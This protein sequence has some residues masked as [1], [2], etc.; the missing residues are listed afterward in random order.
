MLIES[1]VIALIIGFLSGGKLNPLLEVRLR[2]VGLLFLGALL[3]ALAFWSVRLNLELGHGIIPVVH[4]ISY[5]F[6]LMFTAYNRSLPGLLWISLGILLNAVVIS[7]NGGLMPVDPSFVPEVSRELLLV[8]TG[9]HGIL[10]DSTRLS[11][12]TDIFY[13]NIPG[14]GKQLFSIGDL[15]I[16]LGI[17]VF[18]VKRMRL[19][20]T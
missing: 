12:L 3:Q 16:D 18:I 20:H 14:L 19:S 6:L 10:T 4:S 11:F 17:G 13:A 7:L 2:K 5:G 9:T 8:G 15:F 1:F